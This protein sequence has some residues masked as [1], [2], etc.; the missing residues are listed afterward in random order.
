MWPFLCFLGGCLD[1]AILNFWFS[2]GFPYPHWH[3][4]PLNTTVITV[5]RTFEI[6]FHLSILIN[7]CSHKGIDLSSTLTWIVWEKSLNSVHS[8]VKSVLILRGTPFL[9]VPQNSLSAPQNLKMTLNTD[10]TSTS[11]SNWPALSPDAAL[12]QKVDL[13]PFH[14]SGET[15]KE[16]L[17]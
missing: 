3:S 17:K 4:S 9:K 7:S 10:E 14:N 2:L 1:K 16:T 8:S 15:F 6:E 12:N 13:W 11:N 5:A